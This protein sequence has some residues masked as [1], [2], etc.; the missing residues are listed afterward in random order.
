[1]FQSLY[2]LDVRVFQKVAFSLQI[3][4]FLLVSL[5]ERRSA[6]LSKK[7]LFHFLYIVLLLLSKFC[8]KQPQSLSECIL[9][10]L[11]RFT[12]ILL[13]PASLLS[14][15]SNFHNKQLSHV[16]QSTPAIHVYESI[17]TLIC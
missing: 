7:I 17:P 8:V 13:E 9:R 2:H 11:T 12:N 10:R 14:L 6:A 1:M 15:L 3:I 4:T 16:T 5:K